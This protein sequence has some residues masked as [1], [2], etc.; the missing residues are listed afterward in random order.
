MTAVFLTSPH[1]FVNVRFFSTPAFK[2]LAVL[3][4]VMAFSNTSSVQA[5]LI[6][7]NFTQNGSAGTGGP[8][9]GPTMSGAAVMGSAGDRWNGIN[10]TN[11]NGILL[12]SVDGSPC[13]VTMS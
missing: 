13:P 6:D 3:V 7:V 2:M 11:G 10:G 1:S 8:N 9:P 5:Q 4:F 12:V